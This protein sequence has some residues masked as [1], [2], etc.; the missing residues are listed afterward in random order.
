MGTV[1]FKQK[2][3]LITGA[4][5]GI[6]LCF[7]RQ[8]A[9][10]GCD[11]VLAARR[12]ERL[13]DIK[14]DLEAIHGVKVHTVTVDLSVP[15]SANQI[16]TF[17]DN[18]NLSI[19]ILINNAGNGRQR[20]FNEI[21][22]E[23]HLDT[24][25]LNIASL[26][27]LTHIFSSKMASQ[28]SGYILLLGSVAGYFP[29]PNFASYAASKAYVNFLGVALRNEIK[30]R[31]VTV[32]VLNPGA[33]KTEFSDKAGQKFPPLLEKF[34]FSKPDDVAKAGLDGLRKGKAKVVPGLKNKMIVVLMRILPQKTQAIIGKMIFR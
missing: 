17:I 6:G 10:E 4:T 22:V 26:T 25:N 32:T 14:S 8:L 24:I 15:G 21:A 3:A 19:D 1:S 18:A 12:S 13:K 20:H 23:D 7:A 27:E 30:A 34:M 9:S 11:L 28:G 5:S 16:V 33:T 31:G 29:V 2:T